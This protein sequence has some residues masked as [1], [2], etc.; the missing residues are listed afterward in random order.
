LKN[1]TTK[2][3]KLPYAHKVFK[4]RRTCQAWSYLIGVRINW[5]QN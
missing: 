4:G 1:C 5:G 2:F 3:L